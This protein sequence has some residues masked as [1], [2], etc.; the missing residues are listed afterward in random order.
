[1]YRYECRNE[2][3]NTR[4]SRV[5]ATT[6][7]SEAAWD[8]SSKTWRWYKRLTRAKTAS[9]QTSWE[10]SSCWRNKPEKKVILSVQMVYILMLQS[11][12]LVQSLTFPFSFHFWCHKAPSIKF[13][14]VGSSR[15]PWLEPVRVVNRGN[16]ADKPEKKER[17]KE[18]KEKV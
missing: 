6:P 9:P 14:R 12:N 8:K 4:I 2:L 7:S 11:S 10:K 1:M 13:I 17:R 16:G 5:Q 15:D 3:E 18:E